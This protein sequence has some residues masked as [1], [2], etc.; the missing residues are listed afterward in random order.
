[1]GARLRARLLSLLMSY[2]YQANIDPLSRVQQLDI[3]LDNGDTAVL[4]MGHYYDLSAAELARARQYINLISA[5][6]PAEAPDRVYLL[7]IKGDPHD[8]DVPVWSANEA[9]FV[10]EAPATGG[11]GGGTG[12]GADAL[13]VVVYSGSAW[14]VRP[15]GATA[16]MWI[17]PVEPPIGGGGAIEGVDVWVPTA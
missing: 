5:T 11:G 6:D 2:L 8:G 4:E 13:G 9:A 14:S 12:L 10:P 17:G 1:M 3:R 7:P 15:S 16:V